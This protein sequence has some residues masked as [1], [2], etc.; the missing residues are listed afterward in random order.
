MANNLVFQ[1]HFDVIRSVTSSMI[2]Y[3]MSSQVFFFHL[4][5]V[6]DIGNTKVENYHFRKI[7]HVTFTNS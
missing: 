7:I 2:M 4:L 5:A 6:F 1:G 3:L